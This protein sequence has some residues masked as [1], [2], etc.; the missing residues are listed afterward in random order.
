MSP[1]SVQHCVNNA[2]DNSTNNNNNNRDDDDDDDNNNNNDDNNGQYSIDRMHVCQA[3]VC[4]AV[5]CHCTDTAIL[6]FN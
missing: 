1:A 3:C 6:K 4:T 2:N 5:E